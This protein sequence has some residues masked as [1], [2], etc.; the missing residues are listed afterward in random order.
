MTSF[1]TTRYG[2]IQKDDEF[3]C[4]ANLALQWESAG[5]VKAVNEPYE[6][7]VIRESPKVPEALKDVPLESGTEGDAGSSPAVPASRK[8]TRK[9]SRAKTQ[10]S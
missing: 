4:D 2:D 7:K 5:M 6:T 8:K 10:S 3:E 1:I 9:S